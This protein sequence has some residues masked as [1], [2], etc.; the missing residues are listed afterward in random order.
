MK[1]R[2][3]QRKATKGGATPATFHEARAQDLPGKPTI[4][5]DN[6]AA[7]V[8]QRDGDAP[9]EVHPDDHDDED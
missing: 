4:S 7:N 8:G 1:R 2:Q 5:P 9:H 6:H 3:Q